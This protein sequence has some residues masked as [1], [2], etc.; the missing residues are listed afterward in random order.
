MQFPIIGRE[1]GDGIQSWYIFY[2]TLKTTL[3]EDISKEVS[4]QLNR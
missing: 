3:V 2:H 1:K 4:K